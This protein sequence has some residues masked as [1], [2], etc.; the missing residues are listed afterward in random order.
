MNSQFA[1]QEV[2]KLTGVSREQLSYLDENNLIK[3][4]KIGHPKRPHCLYSWH[5]LIALCAYARLREKYSFQSLREIISCLNA[6]AI[7]T[8]LNNKRLIVIDNEL[9]WVENN[10]DKIVSILLNKKNQGKT[11]I[12]FTFSELMEDIRKNDDG[13]VMN[14]DD[15][16]CEAA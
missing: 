12:S 10:S 4:Q 15:R 1:R 7:E 13:S 3:P 8:L 16:L 2:I 9:I 14:L 6:D 11:I 5:Q